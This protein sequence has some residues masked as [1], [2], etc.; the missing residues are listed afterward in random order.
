MLILITCIFLPKHGL[1]ALSYVVG[2]GATVNSPQ[3]NYES[4]ERTFP[5]YYV[6]GTTSLD[7]L[8]Y[9]R[10]FLIYPEVF[11]GVGSSSYIK[12]GLFEG[13]INFV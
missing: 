7:V 5:K 8:L 2:G 4:R 13:I 6:A 9:E 12:T 10:F 3:Y 11:F 1:F